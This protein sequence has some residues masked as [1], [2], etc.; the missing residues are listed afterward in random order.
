M[1]VKSFEFFLFFAAVLLLQYLV[2]A[3]SIRWQNILLLGASYAF[4]TIADWRM[5]PF[6]L[7]ETAIFFW[8][9]LQIPK[10]VD[11]AKAFR[12]LSA[13]VALGIG[14]LIYF[15][16]LNFLVAS[17]ADILGLFGTKPVWSTVHVL[18]P[19][20]V[21]FFTFRLVSYLVDIYR[22]K[23]DPTTDFVAFAGYVS[24]FPSVVAGPIDRPRPFLEQLRSLRRFDRDM[25]ADGFRQILWGLFKKTVIA[26]NLA[27][28]VDAIWGG[29]GGYH[30]AVLVLGAVL[31]SLQMYTDFSGYSDMAIGLGKTMGIRITPNFRYPFF[32]TNVAEYWRGWH[33][34][35]T[36]WLTDYVFMPL[37][38]AF[39]DWG[40]IGLCLA[41]VINLVVVGVWHG[42][43]WTFALFGLY[44][45]LLFVP[46]VITGAFTR[47]SVLATGWLGL[48]RVG[49]ALRMALTFALI[50]IGLVIFRSSDVGQALAYLGNMVVPGPGFLSLW[51]PIHARAELVIGLTFALLALGLEWYQRDREYAVAFHPAKVSLPVR[52]AVYYGLIVVVLVFGASSTAFLY[53]QF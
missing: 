4:Y 13:G 12:L 26:D 50:T 20:G 15:K 40:K 1:A 38:V 16:Y 2:F 11:E 52:W 44:H 45:G 53:A 49:T 33:M 37:N 14:A 29:H 41:I 43:N 21:S 24:F 35:L 8:V 47:K 9:G 17:F 36:S 27:V 32:S 31:F 48:P 42:A 28:V 30:G 18:V 6:L 34:S 3:K 22:G 5:A 51:D 7:V 25:V 46:L 10:I 39:R 23:M 19:L